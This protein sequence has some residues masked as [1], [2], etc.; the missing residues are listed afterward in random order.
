MKYILALALSGCGFLP[1]GPPPATQCFGPPP[2]FQDIRLA[3]CESSD[4]YMVCAYIFLKDNRLC[5]H[6]LIQPMGEC[7]TPFTYAGTE[8]VPDEKPKEQQQNG[9][10]TSEE[11]SW[12]TPA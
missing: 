8:C 6:V 4:A 12:P 9:K 1:L 10:D 11:D 5:Y 3:Q 7:G 2:K